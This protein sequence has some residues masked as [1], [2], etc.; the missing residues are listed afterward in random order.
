[1]KTKR[2]RV[3][4]PC[5]A[6]LMTLAFLA[7]PSPARAQT[8]WST[9]DA[10]QNIH[11]TNTGNVGVGTSSP[12]QTLEIYRNNSSEGYQA[13]GLTI[14]QAG[15]GDAT[16]NFLL[17]GVR[18]FQMGVD[19]SDSDKFKIF[20]DNGGNFSGSGITIDTSGN[21]GVGTNN[22]N[23]YG[24]DGMVNSL[25]LQAV[26]TN[27]HG[28][29]TAA[30]TGAGNGQIALGNST[31]RRAVI[32][33]VD[34]SHLL[35][36]VNNANSGMTALEALRITSGGKVGIG[37]TNPAAKLDVNAGSNAAAAI[38]VTGAINATGA[39]TGATVNATYQDVAEWV[40]STQKLRAGTVVVLDKSETNHV[41][42]STKSYDTKVAGVVS[43]EPGVI[44][45][46]G[47][48]GKL[49]V[50]TTGRVRVRVDATRS[51]VEVGDLLVTSD[52]EG[53]AMK[54]VE[55]DLGG[56]R[57]H[58]PGTIIGKALEPLASGTGEILVLLSL[59]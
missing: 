26:G 33:A 24:D 58:R 12:N 3:N 8:P 37:T 55:V 9:P 41:L 18:R 43:A 49:K 35:F 2:M 30:G 28:Q 11:S 29:I 14:Q 59:Q 39:I 19:N 27:Q 25:A 4:A 53:V 6:L 47:G 34:G 10:S 16:I 52:V 17:T 46:V 31:I 38:N 40:P 44:L 48:E 32:A 36:Y 13:P 15:T 20:S 56:V 1:M 54:S 51:P 57:I 45:G 5:A 50:A 23:I 21:V 7:L 42:A 22:P